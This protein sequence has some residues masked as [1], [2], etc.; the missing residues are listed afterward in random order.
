MSS[1]GRLPTL[2]ERLVLHV[3]GVLLF[4]WVIAGCGVVWV[5]SHLMQQAYDRALIEDAMLVAERM[6]PDPGSPMGAAL[7]ITPNDLRTVLFDTTESIYFVVTTTQG[8]FVAGHRALLGS[9]PASFEDLEFP[10]LFD[11]R[12]S[13][14]RIRAASIRRDQPVPMLI[15]VAQTTSERDAMYLKLFAMMLAPLVALLLILMVGVRRLVNADLA[16]LVRLERELSSR[17]ARDLSP[18]DVRSPI[19]DFVRLGDS[20]N[21]LLATIRR[22]A[23][24]QREFSGN[25]AHEL[26]TP[27]SGIRA[28]AELGLKDG[29]LQAM[30]A[31]LEAIIRTQDRA[32]RLVDQLLALAF[33]DEVSGHL[34]LEPVRLDQVVR[35][36]MLRAMARADAEGIDLGASGLDEP[37]TVMG[38]AALIEGILINLIDN[39]CRHAFA[40]NPLEGARQITVSL[41][42]QPADRDRGSRVTM[43]VT[44]NGAGLPESIRSEVLH[45][46]KRASR[47]PLLREGAGL[48]LAIVNEY[49][50]LLQADLKLAAGDGGCGLSVSLTLD[51][52]R[53]ADLVFGSVGTTP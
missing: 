16:P 13:G 27:L 51:Q 5:A 40:A 49:A 7:R 15:T 28:L 52:T 30:R 45:R 50:R 32:S 37:I 41:V 43:A 12:L 19:R 2:G 23:S 42:G 22:S 11:S 29:G 25:I 39:A 9:M 36:V 31:Q 24:A 20:F 14:N 3:V 18:I 21:T 46:W 35:E 8:D 48:G 17:G 4:A 34:Q 10:R 38:N 33:A 26:R 47:D 6:E 1:F 44:D 53:A